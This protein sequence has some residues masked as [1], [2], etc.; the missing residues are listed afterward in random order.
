MFPAYTLPCG[1][2]PKIILNRNVP[3]AEN[4]ITIISP[5]QKSDQCCDGISDGSVASPTFF[6][7]ECTMAPPCSLRLIHSAYCLANTMPCTL[8]LEITRAQMERYE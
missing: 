2:H 4:P 1:S 8:I 3:P 6:I 7:S 5:S